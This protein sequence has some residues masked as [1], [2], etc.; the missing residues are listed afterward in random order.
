MTGVIAFFLDCQC[1]SV[2]VSENGRRTEELWW[3]LGVGRRIISAS[4]QARTVAE[5]QGVQI[6]TSNHKDEQ[7][8]MTFAFFSPVKLKQFHD[9]MYDTAHIYI[10]ISYGG[11]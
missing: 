7:T 6:V 10:G 8:S 2:L 1:L 5:R 11:G 9:E 4:H 3:K